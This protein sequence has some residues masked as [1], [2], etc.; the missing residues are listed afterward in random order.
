MTVV[1]QVVSLLELTKRPVIRQ[2]FAERDRWSKCHHR[3]RFRRGP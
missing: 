2:R 3:Q 1:K